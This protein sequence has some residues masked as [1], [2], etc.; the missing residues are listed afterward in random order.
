MNELIDSIFGDQYITLNC[1]GGEC[2][3][4]SQIP[5]YVRPPKPDNSK[6]VAISLAIAGGLVLA[7]SAGP[8]SESLS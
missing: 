1:E 3:H 5:G 4:K 6:W 8:L 7:V 2:L